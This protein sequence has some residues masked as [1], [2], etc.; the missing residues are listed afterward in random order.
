MPSQPRYSISAELSTLCQ[1]NPHLY[2]M[3]AIKYIYRFRTLF[4]T[5]M[6]FA[7]HLIILVMCTV[8][9][10]VFVV[11]VVVCVR[12]AWRFVCLN[13]PYLIL[14]SVKPIIIIAGVAH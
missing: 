7:F 6:F 9:L 12:S 2:D 1:D 13:R 8:E 3:L 14:M 10:I 5:D 4:Y 11:V